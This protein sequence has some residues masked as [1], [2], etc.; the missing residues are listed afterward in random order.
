[1]IPL[2]F[3]LIFRAT[4]DPCPVQNRHGQNLTHILLILFESKIELMFEKYKW[5]SHNEGLGST[6]IQKNTILNELIY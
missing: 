4:P 3:L 2:Q 5:A 6:I 1:M